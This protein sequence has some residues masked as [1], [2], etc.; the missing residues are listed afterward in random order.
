VIN[1]VLPIARFYQR[2]A[3]VKV[4]AAMLAAEAGMPAQDLQQAE[5]QRAMREGRSRELV[6][7]EASSS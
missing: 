4:R 7:L 1:P 3:A 2:M 6:G 5:L